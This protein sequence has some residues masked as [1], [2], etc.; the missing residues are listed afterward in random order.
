[1]KLFSRLWNR[2]RHTGDTP[3][4]AA[5]PAPE[6]KTKLEDR[7]PVTDIPACDVPAPVEQIPQKDEN[8]DAFLSRLDEEEDEGYRAKKKANPYKISCPPYR[9][10]D[11]KADDDALPPGWQGAPVI[12][13]TSSVDL[14]LDEI[15]G[16]APKRASGPP[17]TFA[18][19]PVR[20]EADRYH[21]WIKRV[22]DRVT[23][24]ESGQGRWSHGMLASGHEAVTIGIP[25]SVGPDIMRSF[26]LRLQEAGFTLVS[27]GD[28]VYIAHRHAR[29]DGSIGFFR[30]TVTVTPEDEE[31]TK[32]N[33]VSLRAL[34]KALERAGPAIQPTDRSMLLPIPPGSAS[35]CI[36]A[37]PHPR[38]AFVPRTAASR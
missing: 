35:P 29:K 12:D 9:G 24:A 10:K 4:P 27:E 31:H 3:V 6:T 19:L 17:K 15:M 30:I 2:R 28:D 23:P 37:E 32:T 25:E 5:V 20:T 34:C 13:D 7:T 21:Q 11:G 16:L 22:L 18:P 33:P 26:A 1:M 8:L 14:E 38:H 36:P